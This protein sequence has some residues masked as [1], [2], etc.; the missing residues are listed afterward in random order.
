MPRLSVLD[1]QS[2]AF[3]MSVAHLLRQIPLADLVAALE[4][5]RDAG[6]VASRSMIE[7]NALFH[8]QSS[9][10]PSVLGPKSHAT[11]MSA[12][13]QLELI[14]MAES[15]V[16]LVAGSDADSVASHSTRTLSARSQKLSWS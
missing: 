14:H 12:A 13:L 9:Q 7:S 1:P 5:G 4:V 6:S 8:A 10:M 16:A 11:A 3:L 15:A 2:H